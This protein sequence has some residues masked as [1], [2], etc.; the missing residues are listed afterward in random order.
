MKLASAPLHYGDQRYTDG[1]TRRMLSPLCGLN[2]SI[3]SF[4]RGSADPRIVVVGAEI[5][6]VHE[7]LGRPPPTHSYH[8]GGGGVFPEEALIRTLGESL[9]RYAQLMGGIRH[10]GGLRFT[11]YDSLLAKG[12]RVVD[13]EY[14]TFFEPHQLSQP[15]FLFEAF[16]RDAP[17]AW[18]HVRSLT[19]GETTWAPAQILTLGYNVHQAAGEPWIVSAV[20]TGTAAHTD[21]TKALRNCILELIQLDTVM[22]HWY[23]DRVARRIELDRRTAPISRILGKFF[24]RGLDAAFYTIENADLPGHH[25]ACKITDADGIP[26]IAIG[27]GTDTNLVDA[28][29]KAMLE[30]VGVVKLARLLAIQMQTR[31]GG[32]IEIDPTSLYDLD[33]NVLYYALPENR[34]LLE[35]RFGDDPAVHASDLDPD[36]GPDPAADVRGLVQAFADTGKD[37]FFLDLTT[38]DIAAL[39]FYAFRAWSPQTLALTLPSA[40]A[41][42]HAR[43]REYGGCTHAEPHPYP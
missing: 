41:L 27:L 5:T 43:Y 35:R 37:L 40:P 3:Q 39:G 12:E 13:P 6:G 2:T 17:V 8:I 4:L 25:I 1:L 19:G 36:W 42:A 24:Q 9:E 34:H 16:R 29:Y 14:L 11:S 7:I 38:P 15:G 10:R 26:S 20:T 31:R 33:N 30:G 18:L 22:G 23:T 28:M 32:A 21:P